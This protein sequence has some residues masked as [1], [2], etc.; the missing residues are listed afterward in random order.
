MSLKPAPPSTSDFILALRSLDLNQ[1]DVDCIKQSR[2]PISVDRST[3]A[4][5]LK[6]A[7]DRGEGALSPERSLRSLAVVV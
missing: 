3:P 6:P 7:L 4:F 1:N 2:V 5:V